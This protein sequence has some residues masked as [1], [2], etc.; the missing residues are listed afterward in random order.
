[1]SP[2]SKSFPVSP[3]LT[4][5]P[6]LSGALQLVVPETVQ[7]VAGVDAPAFVERPWGSI[8]YSG[9]IGVAGVDA[10]AFVERP[11]GSIDYSGEIG[12][13]GVDAP[14]FVERLNKSTAIHC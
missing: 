7:G 9:E 12:V 11:W 3:G 13:A 14:A 4:L 5:R 1:M 10:P 6:S 8:D 2:D